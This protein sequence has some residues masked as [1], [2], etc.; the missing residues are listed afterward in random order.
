MEQFRGEKIR[1]DVVI[2]GEAVAL[3]VQ[4]ASLPLRVVSA[5]IDVALSFL[6]CVITLELVMVYYSLPFFYSLPFS[7]PA[8]LEAFVTF[9]I[10]A[11][12]FVFPILIETLTRGRSLGKFV[13][14]T[15]VVRD[16]GGAISFRHAFVRGVLAIGEFWMTFGAAALLMA[17]FNRRSK[18]IGDLLAGTYVITEQGAVERQ[19]LVLAPELASWAGNVNVGE[20]DGPLAVMARRFLQT[21]GKMDPW[22]RRNTALQIASE[23]EPSVFPPPPPNTDPERFIAAVLVLRRDAQYRT[24]RAREEA[25]EKKLT[26]LNRAKFGVAN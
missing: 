7:N 24:L 22:A 9:D 23:L 15:R 6:G 16:D 8:Q 18:R 11:W 4:P 26:V 19:P 20:I 1:P 21:A 3:L 25:L 12:I 14:G 10:A 13:A 5:A 2:T 17:S